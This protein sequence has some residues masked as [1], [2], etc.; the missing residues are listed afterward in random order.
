MRYASIDLLRTVAIFVMVFVHFGENLA[1]YTPRFAGFG[2]PLF[3]FLSG[4]SYFLWSDARLA[5]GATDE[6]VSKVSVRRGLFVFG[7]GFAFNLFVWLPEG[8]F[9]WDVLTFIGAALLFLNVARRM[10]R[11]TCVLVAVMAM[12][13]SPVLRRMAD[14]P[15]YWT[16]GYFECDLT[17]S[18]VLVGF[19]STGYFPIFPWIAFSLAGY[20]T[21]SWLFAR[22]APGLVG[23]PDPWRPARIG[24]ALAAASLA[25]RFARPW[26]P[27]AIASGMLG[28][29]TMF[30]PTTEYVLGT[31]GMA[32]ALL[33]AAHRYIDLNPA[34]RRFAGVLSVAKAF[35]GFSLSI[36]VL[37]HLVHVWPLWAYGYSRTGEPTEY[38]GKAMGVGPSMA[39]AAAFLAC[40]WLLLRVLGPDRRYGLERCMRWVCD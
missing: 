24:L 22:P 16:N 32:L 34:S 6:E 38:W 10:P 1:G 25:L 39:L 37:H 36:Y 28:G 31:L 9:N 29:W 33:S 2:A 11:P 5:R 35:S 21:A 4:A 40:C 7:A 27:E 12:L 20:V 18:D 3:V 26:L 8:I 30:P 19:L 15:A 13:V 23:A 14:Y 17:L